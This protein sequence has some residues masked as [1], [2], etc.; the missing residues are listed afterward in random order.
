MS[1]SFFK[2][3]PYLFIRKKLADD[4]IEITISHSNT[5]Q[6]PVLH[7]RIFTVE[8]NNTT[9]LT[10]D[11][12]LETTTITEHP[13]LGTPWYFVHPCNTREFMKNNYVCESELDYLI[14]W[15]SLYGKACGLSAV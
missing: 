6:V 15:V 4:S 9:K 1:H 3:T 12:S 11:K 8:K 7:Y 5:Y 13:I 10:F 2:K 14:K